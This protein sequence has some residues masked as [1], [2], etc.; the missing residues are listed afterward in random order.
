MRMMG[1]ESLGY[2]ERTVLGRGDDPVASA[3]DYYASRGETPM[4]WGGSGAALLGL[5]GEVGL[6]EWRAIFATGGAHDPDTHERLVACMRPG[7]E[8][9]IS[10]H[11]S[12]AELGVLGKPEDMHAV[13]DAERDATL[14]YLDKVV[15]EQ[16]GRRGR[17]QV[18][19]PTGGLTWAVSRHATTRNGDPQPHDHALLANL[20]CMRD[21]R[22]GWKALDTALLRDHLHAATAIGRMGAAAKAVEL[23]YAIERDD[24]RSGRLGSWAI[25][26]IPKEAWEVHA[27]RQA[28][29]DAA[30]GK[31]ASYRSRAIA[32]RATRTPKGHHLVEDLVPR[33]R[34]DL[35]GAGYP[36]EELSRSIE[37][38]GL[39][40]EP[41][42]PSLDEVAEELLGAGGRLSE[43]KTFTRR[44]VIVAVAPHLFGLPVSVLD[45][46]IEAVLS[47]EL[48]V[49]L[50]PVAGARERVWAPACVLEDEARIAELAER[51]ARLPG[52]A[53]DPE[54]AA[55]AVLRTELA[56][57]FR[58]SERQAE[59]AKGLL[60]SGHSPDFLIG[61]AGSGK[62]STLSAVRAGFESEGYRVLGAATS[63]Q[64]ARALGEGAGV[65]SRTVASLTW[66][67]GHGRQALGPRHVLL[68]DEGSMTAD[69][70]LAKVL[71]AAEAAGAKIIITGDFRQ[72]GAVGPGGAL[73]ALV[74][75]HPGHVRALTDNLRQRDP[76][77]R[78]A[79]DHLRAGSLPSALAWYMANGRVHPAPSRE[80]AMYEMVKSWAFDVA[81]D[82]DALLVAY[83]RA[84]IE[85]LNRA[86]REVWQELGNLTGPELEAPG[87]RRY[88]AGDKVVT[89][90]PGPAGAWVTSERAVVRS[91]DTERGSLVALTPDG[92]QLHMRPDDIGPDKLAHGYAITAHRSQGLT[93]DVTYALEDGGGRELAYV[94]MSRARGE[95]HVQVV[96]GSLAEAVSRLAWAWGQ[97]R[98][99]SWATG[100]GEEKSLAELSVERARL[101]RSLPPDVSAQLGHVRQQ[102]ERLDRDRA[103]L[104]AG[105]GRW[106]G[107]RAGEA[108]EAVCRA[109]VEHE[110][111]TRA[112]EDEG[113]GWWGRHKARRELAGAGARFDKA[114]RAWEE[115]GRPHD[116]RLAARREHIAGEVAGLAHEQA[117]RDAYL[118][119]H[120]EVP[121]RLAELGRAIEREEELERSRSWE[122]IAQ[123][124][125]ARR[126]GISHE[127]DTGLGIDL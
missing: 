54:D 74:S 76:A 33:W 80:V 4:V 53:L 73:E 89:L 100:N 102:L 97:E 112:L 72:L 101:L 92:R 44:D 127:A 87:G 50:P 39:N 98:R 82:R 85:I 58:L 36:P 52:P 10:S 31:D 114:L 56:G 8:L 55:A 12:V 91:V 66:R 61:V 46:A 75:R 88:R 86:A 15:Q 118:S 18:R 96:A 49:E 71:G 104:R 124:E 45:K 79:L 26:G 35:A 69:A 93:T 110:R 62:T 81:D 63:G 23:G 51:L 57:G 13:L 125:Q 6:D 64:A 106:A 34:D 123:R 115:L 84:D 17:A 108:A 27:S 43:D 70:D 126:L 94:A 111:A 2:H 20:V 25:S 37:L 99:Q 95:S 24:G 117:A 1:A 40:Y 122:R 47:H 42:V 7:M 119:E 29:I 107:T 14:A 19:T 121:G 90:S 3:L 109:A 9:V 28:E 38:A 83:R 120:P 113:L 48:A 68:L 41:P 11:K 77:E 65:D 67:L 30:V 32:A 5:S 78:H 60:T 105:E 103:E 116:D 22:G 21:Q 59:V 16:G